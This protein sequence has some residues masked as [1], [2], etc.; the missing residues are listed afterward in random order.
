MIPEYESFKSWAALSSAK[1]FMNIVAYIDESGTHDPTG[2]LK[3]S[4]A[5][6]IG[7]VVAT[8]EEWITF[9]CQWRKILRKYKAC[10]FHFREQFA[11]WRVIAL[12]LEP[13]ADYK[14]NPYRKWSKDQ[15]SDFVL[16]LAPLAGSKIIV[17]GWVPTKLYNED[18][19]AGYPTKQRHPYELCLDHF[20]NSILPP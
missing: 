5:V 1:W 13:S 2:K 4:A 19:I 9:D 18:K 15:L 20:F 11:A 7:G 8:K 12:E 16:E 3:G 14:K 17:A 10:Y 6:A